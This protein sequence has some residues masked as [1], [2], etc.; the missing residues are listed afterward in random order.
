MNI[1]DLKLEGRQHTLQIPRRYKLFVRCSM[2]TVLERV[3]FWWC[4]MVS[5]HLEKSTWN[6][7]HGYQP[8]PQLRHHLKSPSWLP[9]LLYQSKISTFLQHILFEA[10]VRHENPGENPG[11]NVA[12][13]CGGSFPICLSLN[14]ATE[15]NSLPSI[16]QIEPLLCLNQ[17]LTSATKN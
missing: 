15:S 7:R 17:Q 10:T 8:M 16:Q 3:S 1:P 6:F 9:P 13:F 12:S 14:A 2:D 4:W 11:K 5:P